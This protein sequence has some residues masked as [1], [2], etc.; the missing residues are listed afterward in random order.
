[1]AQ[2]PQGG[3]QSGR[4][5]ADNDVYTWLVIIGFSVVLATIVFVVYRSNELFGTP[6]PGIL[7]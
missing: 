4:A 2:Q 1:M 5:A 7:T 3:Y 6:L